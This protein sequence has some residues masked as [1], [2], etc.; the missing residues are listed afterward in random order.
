MVSRRLVLASA[1]PGRLALLRG[2]G[3][4]PEVVVSGVA[5]DR[6]TGLA[7]A[8]A[9]R[10]LAERK[11]EAVAQRVGDPE[12][13][14]RREAADSGPAQTPV[15]ARATAPP[16]LVVGCDSVLSID[17]E[18]RGKPASPEQA[19]TWW[20]TQ[21]GGSGVLVT[22]HAVVDLATGRRA[23][24]LAETVVRFGRPSDAE[25]DAYVA[26]GEPLAVAGAFT[27]AGY[28]APFVDA[29]DGDPSTVIGLSLP[30]LRR[31]LAD[32][33]ISITDLWA[34]PG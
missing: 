6:V 24:G 2:A 14:S 30:L 12:A 15:Q 9:A 25:I 5:E 26:T 8:D 27:L 17:G 4:A 1:S 32:L 16:P 33:G 7:A 18:V 13:A 28:A 29:I 10:T 34:R 31:L 11:A 20:R 21:R 3:L 22:G 23:S 19:R